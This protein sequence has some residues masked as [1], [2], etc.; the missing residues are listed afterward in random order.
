M[1]VPLIELIIL[2]F[3]SM[4]HSMT[5]YDLRKAMDGST[6]MF[7][8][9]SFG[10]I[11][12]ALKKLYNKG[13]L[14]M[15]EETVN[16]RKKKL[17]SINQFGYDYFNTLIREDMG[18]DK[19]KIGILL[20]VFFFSEMSLDEQL[21]EI[22]R[23]LE[24]SKSNM[25]YLDAIVEEGDQMVEC[26]NESYCKFHSDAARFGRDYEKFVQEWFANYRQELKGRDKNENSP[27]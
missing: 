14:E 24:R 12:P 8:T 21:F 11:N 19:L 5:S 1:E 3:L 15:R 6:N 2:G 9:T 27:L 16:N 7:M 4:G 17:Y 20:K 13:Y 18:P 22:E 10:A 23:H 26:G 25:T